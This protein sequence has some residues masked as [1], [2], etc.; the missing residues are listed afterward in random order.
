MR[1]KSSATEVN[2]DLCTTTCCFC[3]E[4]LGLDDETNTSGRL[5]ALFVLS[6]TLGLPPGGG[7]AQ[8]LLGLRRPVG[9]NKVGP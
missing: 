8:A 5:E 1:L 3:R 7:T 6:L 2:T 4:Q 9:A